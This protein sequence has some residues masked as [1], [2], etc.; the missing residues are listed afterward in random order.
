MWQ[1][2]WSH[3]NQQVWVRTY[4]ETRFV[5]TRLSTY[6]RFNN[7]LSVNHGHR[8]SENIYIFFRIRR[9]ER[10]KKTGYYVPISLQEH[11]LALS[12]VLFFFWSQACH[13]NFSVSISISRHVFK[14]TMPW[15]AISPYEK[16]VMNDIQDGEA[17]SVADRLREH[18]EPV[19]SVRKIAF[20]IE[21]TL[22]STYLFS[23]PLRVRNNRVSL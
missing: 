2:G 3:I 16:R 21:C 22:V 9:T 13:P 1:V 6:T 8:Q 11:F 20:W 15:K 4:S 12:L 19:L 23:F 14:F 10:G 5:S 7:V 18:E 17:S